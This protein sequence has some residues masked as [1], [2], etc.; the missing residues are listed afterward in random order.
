M[1]SSKV[2]LPKNYLK[3]HHPI[4]SWDKPYKMKNYFKSTMKLISIAAAGVG[5]ASIVYRPF[6]HDERA[7]LELSATQT[8]SAPESGIEMKLS[9][10]NPNEI[11]YLCIPVSTATRAMSKDSRLENWIIP[12]ATTS[13]WPEGV[14]RT[15]GSKVA[16][17]LTILINLALGRALRGNTC[18]LVCLKTRKHSLKNIIKEAIRK[19]FIQVSKGSLEYSPK[20]DQ[21][22]NSHK[23]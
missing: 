20:E 15:I 23:L 10:I 1:L 16:L 18:I 7:S 12:R 22:H 8:P 14:E 6:Y 2:E 13:R 21:Q 9:L 17:F 3:G 19:V 4:H 11:T 5:L